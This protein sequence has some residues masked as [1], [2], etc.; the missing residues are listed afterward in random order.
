MRPRV[1]ELG[2]VCL[3]RGLVHVSVPSGLRRTVQAAWVLIRWWYLQRQCRLVT[4][5]GPL[6]NAMVWSRSQCTAARRQP[7][8]RQRRSRAL[9]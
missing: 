7:R 9:T 1:V 8:N 4:S 3:P 6:G 2:A 5:V